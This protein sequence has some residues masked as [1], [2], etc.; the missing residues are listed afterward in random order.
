MLKIK[1][2]L[3]KLGNKKIL[4][5]LVAVAVVLAALFGL[6]S[7]NAKK[8]SSTNGKEA[9]T[10][11]VM[12]GD[13]SL[14]ITGSA[15]VEPYERYEIIAKASGD[16]ISCPYEVGDIVNEGTLLYRFDTSE[17]DISMQK[18][19][20]SL[21]NSKTNYEN[22]LKDS[23]KLYIKA[24]SSGII[25]N[26]DIKVG[27]D[28]KN[29]TKVA[30]INNTV[31]LKV[32]LP[33]NELQALAISV[34]DSAYVSSSVHM[35]NVE[36]RVTHKEANAHAGSDG[37]KL[38]NVTIEFE[39]PG[40]F[41]AGMMVGGSVGE[42]V[43]PG[44]GEIKLSDSGIV[45]AEAEGTVTKLYYSNGDYVED[46]ATIAVISSDSV[47]NSIKSSKNNYE[48]AKLSMLDAEEQLE[49]YNLTAPISGTIITKNAKAGDTI[50]KTNSSQILM[51]LADVSRLKF[52]L[53]IDE[54]D[55][56]KVTSGQQVEVTC[57]ALP[58]ETF[59]GEITTI[60]VEGT[61]S[62]GVTT[63]T[64][65]VVINEPGNLRPS[66]N[67]D[68]SVVVESSSNTLYVPSEDV[69]RISNMYYVFKKSD[70]KTEKTDKDDMSQGEMPRRDRPVGMP[71]GE[72][73][74]ENGAQGERRLPEAPEGFETVVVEVGVVG[75]ELTEIL[76]GLSEGDEIYAQSTATASSANMMMGMSGMPGG[77]SGGMPGG[78]RR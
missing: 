43:S 48:S 33:F 8:A 37:S 58:K 75:D 70:G 59:Y 32:T 7:C 36:G 31:L 18:Q 12:R 65:E 5:I 74:A 52:K 16:I 68:A 19:R 40:V 63:Y 25:S 56:G 78:M 69:K 28:V 30:D 61:S 4:I 6:K 11:V 10:D 54:L 35:S 17:T 62:N 1:E 49:D 76:S 41:V 21:D 15:A 29:G 22:A 73:S 45:S 44:S 71:E 2:F 14:T 38:V 47:T 77:M 51:V 42:A 24:N 26:L 55:V 9:G 53:D 23:E 72:K 46:G 27:D 50:D 64:A 39:N 20:I 67:V 13:V 66:M 34:G 3:S 60:S 57:D